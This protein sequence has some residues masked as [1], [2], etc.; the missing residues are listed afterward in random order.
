MVARRFALAPELAAR[1]RVVLLLKGS[2]TLIA[3]PDGRVH[4]NPLGDDALARGGAGDVLTGVIGALLAQG[5]HGA[6]GGAARRPVHGLAADRAAQ[7]RGR[8]GVLTREIADE[9]AGA[10][11]DLESTAWQ[12]AALRRRLWPV[13][14]VPPAPEVAR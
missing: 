3:T 12:D 6:G 13:D 8:R 1:W 2:P 14:G 11:Q 4:V 10:L 5:A 7:A 9:V